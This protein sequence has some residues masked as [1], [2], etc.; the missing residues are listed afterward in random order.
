MLKFETTIKMIN[1]IRKEDF[2]TFWILA[3]IPVI[4]IV[5]SFMHFVYDWSGKIT[6]AGIF[7]PVNESIWEHIKLIFWP[8]LI[9]WAIGYI[10]KKDKISLSQWF[11]SLSIG[12]YVG[13][14]IIVT[15]YYTYTGAFGNYSGFLDISSFIIAVTIAQFF[16]LHIYRYAKL[17]IYDLYSACFITFLFISAIVIFTFSPPQIPLFLDSTTGLY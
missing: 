11:C 8:T 3:G 16:A 1:R 14:L 5:G 6:I 4:S 17:S 13:P 7:S 2:V 15:F 9:W 10:I 12:L